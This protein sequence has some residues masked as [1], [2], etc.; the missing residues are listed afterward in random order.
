MKSTGIVRRIDP[1]G[2]VSLPIEIRK[3]AGM[4]AG[5]PLEFFQK[6]DDS[7]AM[8]AYTPGCAFCN[9]YSELHFFMGKN[10]CSSCAAELKELAEKAV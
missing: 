5:T 4:D 7:I 2:R 3:M 6:G 8:R 1:M 10:I 9:N